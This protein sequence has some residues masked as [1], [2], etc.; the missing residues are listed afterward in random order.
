MGHR[1]FPQVAFRDHKLTRGGYMYAVPATLCVT[2][3]GALHLR[4]KLG[5]TSGTEQSSRR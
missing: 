1:K 4:V 5:S 3:D 2:A